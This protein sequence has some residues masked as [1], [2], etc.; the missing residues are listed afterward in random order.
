MENRETK[1]TQQIRKPRTRKETI[2]DT[3]ET[4]KVYA[5]MCPVELVSLHV[6]FKFDGKLS[7]H[8][9]SLVEYFAP[10]KVDS[11]NS[12]LIEA[13]GQEITQLHVDVL[14]NIVGE[15]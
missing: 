9:S 11:V 15:Q 2:P 3:L 7:S 1:V 14:R 13:H 5:V 12:I 8:V 4:T 6:G 10:E